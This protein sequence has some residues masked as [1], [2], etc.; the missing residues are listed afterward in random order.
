[1]DSAAQRQGRLDAQ[2]GPLSAEPFL[3]TL[4]L[5]RGRNRETSL[6]EARAGDDYR[7]QRQVLGTISSS[8]CTGSLDFLTK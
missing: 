3:V 5:G 4:A 1:M 6:H 7:L 8:P 2:R